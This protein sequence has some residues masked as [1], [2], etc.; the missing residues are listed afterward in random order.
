MR[1]SRGSRARG[2]QRD[3]VELDRRDR[4]GRQPPAR[5]DSLRD[6][7][8]PERLDPGQAEG[9]RILRDHPIVGRDDV[10]AL[11]IECPRQ[12]RGGQD[13]APVVL[14]GPGHGQEAV[15]PRPDRHRAP[16]GITNV[17]LDVGVDEVERGGADP[18]H[19]RQE[20][21]P[22]ARPGD[23]QEGLRRAG[24][25]VQ[26]RPAQGHGRSEPIGSAEGVGH[27]RPVD[28]CP[29]LQLHVRAAA[30]ADPLDPL[31]EPFPLSPVPI[32]RGIVG[33]DVFH[34]EVLHVGLERGHPPGDP[35]VV[36]DQHG[37]DA[38]QRRAR[39][40][41]AGGVDR[42]EVPDGRSAQ[43]EMRIVGEDRFAAGGPGAREDPGVAAQIPAGSDSER[44]ERRR[45]P[46]PRGP[47]R[48]QPPTR[49]RRVLRRGSRRRPVGGGQD[50]RLGARAGQQLGGA[51]R[52]HG[53][54]EAGAA[55]FAARVAGQVPR[56]HLSP[57]ESVGAR[58]RLGR[59]AENPELDRPRGVL[60]QK[61]ID[62]RGVRIED[63]P[64]LGG[65]LRLGELRG[66]PKSDRAKK[67]VGGHQAFP[68]E[69]GEAA[70]A[71][72]ALEFHLPEPVARVDV[73]QPEDRVGNGARP[74]RRHAAGVRLDPHRSGVAARVHGPPGLRERAPDEGGRRHEGDE[75]EG[76]ENS[77]SGS[78]PCLRAVPRGSYARFPRVGELRELAVVNPGEQD[79]R[80]ES[81]QQ[82]QEHVPLRVPDVALR[83]EKRQRGLPGS[84]G[85]P[86][87]DELVKRRDRETDARHQE[88]EP[89]ARPQRR[90]PQEDLPGQDRRHEALHDMAEAVVVIA[91]QAE[92]VTH[93]EAEGHFGVRVVAPDHEDDGMQE[94]Q[95]VR[96][97]RQ[98]ETA[99]GGDEH[100][101]RHDRG[102]D[103]EDP[104]VAV[105][106]ADARKHEQSGPDGQ[107]DCGLAAP[108]SRPTQF[109]QS[110]TMR[111]DLVL[112]HSAALT[113]SGTGQM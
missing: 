63:S 30:D 18:L 108:R 16:G 5:L 36:P 39:R 23:V 99:V 87:F 4:V 111:S 95:A 37:G 67:P 44:R 48:A 98:R 110:V 57:D 20:F 40:P 91:R 31:L 73:A 11:R 69:L 42:G 80:S 1:A 102:G 46:G 62:A 72:P 103:L 112:A 38:G 34:E 105:L 61:R 32:A 84:E 82:A 109:S 75:N 106:G 13:P 50:R 45:R 79:L 41:Q 76:R 12:A 77:E 74:D 6:P 49:D 65:E 29:H 54:D 27:D 19:A 70:R 2:L 78:Q 64:R 35:V 47:S 8:R 33:V 60:G 89:A 93:P 71:D 24:I 3:A 56:H 85:R 94:D 100:H 59:D 10:S 66:A 26:S 52:S 21:G 104:R 107:E 9:I 51:L 28:G 17:A 14:A 25:G 97:G 81:A 53:L 43:P 22:V 68:E 58:P 113:L 15:G 96:E 83:S 55:D 88:E 7:R 101:G 86:P 92:Q 90:L